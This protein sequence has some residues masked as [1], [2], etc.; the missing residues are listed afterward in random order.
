MA[1]LIK[2]HILN[3]YFD[4]IHINQSYPLI[5]Q[6]SFVIISKLTTAN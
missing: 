2:I 6:K 5:G 1:A 4:A 3:D